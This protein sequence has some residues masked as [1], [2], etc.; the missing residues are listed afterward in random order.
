MREFLLKSG[1][2]N[3]FLRQDFMAFIFSSLK[4]KELIL[5][6]SLTALVPAV[7]IAA[8]DW[9]NFVSESKTFSVRLPED[10]TSTRH[11]F[12]LGD[13]AAVN[14][15]EVSSLID[16][17]PYKNTI[18][19]YAIKLDQT[20]GPALTKE[21]VAQLLDQ[22]YNRYEEYYKTLDGEVLSQA[23]NNAAGMFGG[24]I[25]IA[26]KD[27]K[28]GPQRLRAQ[29]LFSETTKVQMIV[30]GSDDVMN[31]F[32]TRDFIESIVIRDGLESVKNTLSE[33]WVPMESPTGMFTIKHPPE[34]VPPYYP[35][36]PTVKTAD[37]VEM[38]GLVF[39][40]P[41]RNESI[42]FNVY[43][44]S[45]NTDLAYENVQEVLLKN[46]IK[47]YRT[48]TNGVRYGK[49]LDQNQKLAFLEAT[50]AINPPKNFPFLQN[51]KLKAYFDGK[52]MI[53]EELMTSND[54]FNASFTRSLMDLVTFHPNKMHA[55]VVPAAEEI[56]KADAPAAPATP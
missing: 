7:A 36:K 55:P 52:N 12:F 24:E 37:K 10:H 46:H 29:I 9:G 21:S 48:G 1:N 15:E 43:G 33:K 20:I 35:L 5:L 41:V 8:A 3:P 54:L 38:V 27:P 34:P 49:G 13:D 22:E 31:S 17:R 25:Y 50:F 18:K 19:S 23:P 53:V 45:F 56:P 14:S 32:Q 47:K 40:D 51:M 44:Y 30:A 16:Q 39:N 11:Q 42:F 28:L 26:Y 6:A 4:S 2:G